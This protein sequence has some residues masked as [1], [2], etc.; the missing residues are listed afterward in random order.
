MGDP[1]DDPS[2]TRD[3][4]VYIFGSFM[5]LLSQNSQNPHESLYSETYIL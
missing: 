3:S 2:T 1:V 4:P 5:E